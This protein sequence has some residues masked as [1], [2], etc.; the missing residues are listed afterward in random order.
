MNLI[1]LCW[2]V[3]ASKFSC[4]IHCWSREQAPPLCKASQ[5]FSLPVA[6]T[7][8]NTGR[9]ESF[10]KSVRIFFLFFLPAHYKLSSTNKYKK[11]FNE[12]TIQEGDTQVYFKIQISKI[13]IYLPFIPVTCH[14]RRQLSV[15]DSLEP[16]RWNGNLLAESVWWSYT[17]EHFQ[18][19]VTVAGF[20]LQD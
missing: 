13:K 10:W 9:N 20:M 5:R 6:V 2:G 12:N 15:A 8:E 14:T 4:C 7:G 11:L 1:P 3:D 18:T 19:F 17:S 16:K